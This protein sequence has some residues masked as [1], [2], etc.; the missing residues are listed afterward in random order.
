[1]SNV[2]IKKGTKFYELYKELK[3]MAEDSCLHINDFMDLLSFPNQD[4]KI[5]DLHSYALHFVK[6]N[7]SIK[8][9]DGCYNVTLETP[10]ENTI[11]LTFEI[12]SSFED[13]VK[14]HLR[15]TRIVN[16]I[17]F[18]NMLNEAGLRRYFNGVHEYKITFIKGK[19]G[20]ITKQGTCISYSEFLNNFFSNPLIDVLGEIEFK[21]FKTKLMIERLKNLQFP[22]D[23]FRGSALKLYLYFHNVVHSIPFIYNSLNGEQRR[24]EFTYQI[25]YGEKLFDGTLNDIFKSQVIDTSDLF[26]YFKYSISPQGDII[27]NLVTLD[28]EVMSNKIIAQFLINLNNVYLICFAKN[29][30]IDVEDNELINCTSSIYATEEVVKSLPREL[31][32]HNNHNDWYVLSISILPDFVKEKLFLIEN[33]DMEDDNE[34]QLMVHY[35]HEELLDIL[36]NS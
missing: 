12:L 27:F 13:I 1:M 32:K 26:P 36:N 24:T 33:D 6:K 35:D 9:F 8:R 17:P 18:I 28:K 19:N 22:E 29:K 4:F 3:H 5:E 21:K 15:F 34:I 20:Y 16:L 11:N 23:G 25:K 2:Q 31:F 7:P 30:W 14:A 10:D